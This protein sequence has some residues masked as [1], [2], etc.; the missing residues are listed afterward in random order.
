MWQR[1]TLYDFRV[2]AHYLGVLLVLEAV[3]LLLPALTA[4]LFQEW[5]PASRYFLGTGVALTVG[6]LLRMMR[7]SPGHLN[8]TQAVAVTGFA[9]IVVALVGALPLYLSVHYA[10]YTD[11]LF[12]AVSYFTTTDASIIALPNHISH[13]DNM[14][15]FIMNYTGGMGLVVVAMSVGLLSRG[16]TSSLYASEGRSEHVVPNVVETAR[17]IFMF[18]AAIILCAGTVLAVVLLTMGM[19]AARAFLH[20][21]WLAMSGFMTAGLSPMSTSVTYYHSM[22]VEF[23]LMTLMIFGGVNFALQSEVWNG[24]FHLFPRDIEVRTAIIWWIGMLV[25]FVIAASASSLGGG[26]PVLMRT[27]LFTFVGAAT[28]TGF[29]T[30]TSTQ[31][32]AL[33]P[34]GAILVLALLMAVG[35]SS[36]STAGGIKLKRIAIIAKSAFETMKNA[37]SSESV[38]NVSS[39]YHLGKIM[40]DEG[41]VKDAMTVTMFYIL[42]Y[43][44]GA[45]AGIAMGYDAV[46]SVSESIAMASNSG[47]TTGITSATMPGVLK[48]IYMLEMWAGRLEI[49][50]LIALGLKIGASLMPRPGL[51][52]GVR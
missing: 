50:A 47:M 42:V 30:M 41:E 3:A 46:A 40:L 37:M 14:W 34:S 18:S 36:G 5:E 23:I 43:V 24:R 44:I 48:V 45:L 2:I 38:R 21:I 28:T 15:R 4:L 8:R 11:A 1:F 17:F 13:A 22:M 10:T 25:V 49:V 12:D 27:G 32:N 52:R 16:G 9:W 29:T 51:K 31:M 19:P 33:L 20:G 35:A 39:Y 7:I 6:T 26:L